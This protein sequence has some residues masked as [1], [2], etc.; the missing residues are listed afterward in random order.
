[1]EDCD[2]DGN[3]RATMQN[4]AH[5]LRDTTTERGEYTYGSNNFIYLP[6]RTSE[7]DEQ[8]LGSGPDYVAWRHFHA[9]G[10]G[11]GDEQRHHR[12]LRGGLRFG[13]VQ[14]LPWRVEAAGP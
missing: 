5:V 7:A 6:L 14:P 3:P 9:L 13:F 10:L 8:S 1:M 4:I 12:S 11:Y 2:G